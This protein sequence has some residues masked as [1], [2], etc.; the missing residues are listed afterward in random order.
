M[1]ISE[2]CH[3]GSNLND[4]KCE[5]CGKEPDRC[6]CSKDANGVICRPYNDLAIAAIIEELTRKN[7]LGTQ[8][9]LAKMGLTD[10]SCVKIFQNVLKDFEEKKKKLG[11]Q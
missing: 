4:G 1:T 3:C 7:G 11:S 9:G 2:K 8:L 6:D 10:E 5:V